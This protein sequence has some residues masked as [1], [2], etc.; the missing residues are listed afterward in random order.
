MIYS[1]WIYILQDKAFRTAVLE[2]LARFCSYFP[3][4]NEAVKRRQKKLLDYDAHR[5]KVRKLVDK[6]SEDPQRL[7]RVNSPLFA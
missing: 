7:P 5:A 3:E 6:P 2:P 1:N 4:V